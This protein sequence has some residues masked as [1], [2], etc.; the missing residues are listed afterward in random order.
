MA[1][2]PPLRIWLYSAV[3][4]TGVLAL[5]TLMRWAPWR[6]PD[7]AIA[8]HTQQFLA[9]P[10]APGNVRVLALGSS[11]LWA[12]TPPGQLSVIPGIEWMRMTKPGTGIGYLKP[13]LEEIAHFP[14]DVLVIDENLLAPEPNGVLAEALRQDFI[15]TIKGWAYRLT[16]QQWF[17]PGPQYVALLDQHAAFPCD[18]ITAAM[19]Q[20]KRAA[21]RA[22]IKS[23]FSKGLVDR[24]LSDQLRRLS[25]RGVRIVLL[26]LRRSEPV[27]QSIAAEKKGWQMRLRQVLPPGPAIRYLA[28]PA[29]AQ[30]NLYCDGSHMNA[31]GARLFAPWWQTQLQQ[32][33]DER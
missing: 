6:A 11:L 2:A 4:A 17:A 29:S 21:V 15:L 26:E 5:L 24:E 3:L 20:Q 18:T 13:S 8:L 32:L 23:W 27:E 22:E 19:P 33:R 31:Q 16:G 1:S 12:S 14:P 9:A 7:M 10:A 28:T 25:H 30:A